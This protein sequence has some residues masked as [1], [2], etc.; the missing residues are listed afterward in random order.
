MKKY[1]AILEI[2]IPIPV[3]IDAVDEDEAYELAE[4]RKD[5]LV[6]SHPLCQNYEYSDF[7]VY[8]VEEATD[9]ECAAVTAEHG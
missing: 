9:E 5:E 8:E 2:V 1:I 3:V 4:E 7:S 6:G